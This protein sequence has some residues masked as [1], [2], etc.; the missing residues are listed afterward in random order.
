MLVCAGGSLAAAV[1]L[2]V[3]VACSRDWCPVVASGVRACLLRGMRRAALWCLLLLDGEWL[4]VIGWGVSALF[5]PVVCE[6]TWALHLDSFMYEWMSWLASTC[7][8]YD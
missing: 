1:G 6:Y 5:S 2:S 7:F 8:M 3:S 4:M